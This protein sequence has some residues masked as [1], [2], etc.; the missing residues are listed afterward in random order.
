MPVIAG[1][2]KQRAHADANQLARQRPDGISQGTVHAQDAIA[3]VM[4]H[5]KIFDGI[6]DLQPV[7]VC[8]INT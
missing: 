3:F 2:G 4:H 7:P 8:L 6:E 1:K 5:N